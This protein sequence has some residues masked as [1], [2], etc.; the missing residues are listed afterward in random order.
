MEPGSS[1]ME[2]SHA[3]HWTTVALTRQD[4]QN[5]SINIELCLFI[6]CFSARS[7][8]ETFVPTL[9]LNDL[10][11]HTVSQHAFTA[12]FV[13][14]S[15]TSQQANITA[16]QHRS[17]SERPFG[18]L[19]SEKVS[20]RFTHFNRSIVLRSFEANSPLLSLSDLWKSIWT[21]FESRLERK[22]LF[23]TKGF[24]WKVVGNS[25]WNESKQR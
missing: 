11:H 8:H 10:L 3:L 19:V 13:T 15:N 7:R 1:R 22:D 23:G 18:D 6:P 25:F 16:S 14:H 20:S 17:N 9:T 4:R 24:V 12:S 5:E 2:S 21:E